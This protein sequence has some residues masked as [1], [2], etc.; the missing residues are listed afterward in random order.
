MAF[1]VVI[2]MVLE[3]FL[4]KSQSEIINFPAFFHFFFLTIE[5]IE[6]EIILEIFFEKLAVKSDIE[7]Y[8][9]WNTKCR[10]I[11][12]NQPDRNFNSQNNR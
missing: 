12:I 11:R 4:E 1:S 6:M 2:E 9:E 8:F 3:I 5:I 7:M 10:M